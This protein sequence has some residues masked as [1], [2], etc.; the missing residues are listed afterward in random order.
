MQRSS[1]PRVGWPSKAVTDEAW[2]VLLDIVEHRCLPVLSTKEAIQG[3]CSKWGRSPVPKEGAEG[4]GRA[5]GK[6]PIVP[7]RG[8]CQGATTTLRSVLPATSPPRRRLPD[9]RGREG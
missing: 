7:D 3:R 2:S 9:E 5:A 4:A 1:R 8:G 6:F